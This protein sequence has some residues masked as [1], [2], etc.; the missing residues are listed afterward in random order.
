VGDARFRDVAS[1]HG[2]GAMPAHRV[3][4]VSGAGAPSRTCEPD[5]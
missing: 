4:G 1:G 3:I 2:Y 5:C